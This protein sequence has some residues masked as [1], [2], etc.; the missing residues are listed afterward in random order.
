MIRRWLDRRKKVPNNILYTLCIY[1]YMWLY[2]TIF[3][4]WS[5]VWQAWLCWVCAMTIVQSTWRNRPTLPRR[6]RTKGACLE[7]KYRKH[8]EIRHEILNSIG[9][10]TKESIYSDTLWAKNF[11]VAYVTPSG[12]VHAS[13]NGAALKQG[14]AFWFNDIQLTGKC[15]RVLIFGSSRNMRWHQP[16]CRWCIFFSSSK[17]SVPPCRSTHQLDVHGLFP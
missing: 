7:G 3:K 14:D 5:W 13:F 1:I 6:D 11:Q 10:A 17:F 4:Q 2:W 15:F 8:Q 9:C 16:M 12:R